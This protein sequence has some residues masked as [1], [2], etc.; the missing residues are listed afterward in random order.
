MC[1]VFAGA[2]KC[3]SCPPGYMCTRRIAADPC[4]QGYY[5]P[6][7]IGYD[8]QPCP[9]GTFGARV[10]LTDIL[11][12]TNCTAGNYCDV[13]GLAAPSGPCKATYW[14]K[15]GVDKRNPIGSNHLGEGGICPKG[16][17]CPEGTDYP[18]PCKVGTY[19]KLEGTSECSMCFAGEYNSFYS[20]IYFLFR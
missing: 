5:C 15:V 2:L 20:Y 14:C 4:K 18:E 17:Q 1:F 8:I 11:E 7:S 10:G 3:S 13:V 19:S 6:G 9:L 12:C 16:H